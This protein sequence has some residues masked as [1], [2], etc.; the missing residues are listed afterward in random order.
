[1]EKWT[2]EE[3]YESQH[4]EHGQEF[5]LYEDYL[6]LEKKAYRFREDAAHL[7]AYQCLHKEEIDVAEGEDAPFC[8]LK[9][10]YNS[11]KKRYEALLL[12]LPVTR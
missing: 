8:T 2:L 12:Q 1:M 7:S 10:N 5:V 3:I 9:R 11:L 4:F 6:E